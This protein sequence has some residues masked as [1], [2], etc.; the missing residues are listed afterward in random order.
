MPSAY[1]YKS[2]DIVSMVCGVVTLH[3]P[4]G[5]YSYFKGT[6]TFMFKCEKLEQ[7]HMPF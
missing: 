6:S 5:K 1:F 4:V 2:A 3:G 7:K